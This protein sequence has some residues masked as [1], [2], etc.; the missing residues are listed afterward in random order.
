MYFLRKAQEMYSIPSPKELSPSF[1]ASEGK[2]S[3]AA[4][5]LEDVLSGIEH[6]LGF[7]NSLLLGCS[8]ADIG[9]NA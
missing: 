7:E 8:M 5:G 3:M 1:W 4:E 6:P 9:R 2:S